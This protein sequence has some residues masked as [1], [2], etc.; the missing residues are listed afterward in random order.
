MLNDGRP[1][2][3]EKDCVAALFLFLQHSMQRMQPVLGRGRGWVC[4]GRDDVKGGY[5][6]TSFLF[7]QPCTQGGLVSY[8][9]FYLVITR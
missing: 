1:A 4:G 6:F 2:S 8:K 7:C 5:V 3:E 9:D